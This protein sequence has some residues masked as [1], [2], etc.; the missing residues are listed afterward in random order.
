MYIKLSNYKESK[1]FLVGLTQNRISRNNIPPFFS[2]K[3]E[4][5]DWERVGGG[6]EVTLLA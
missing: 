2:S 1:N 6:E 5:R 4:M 3:R